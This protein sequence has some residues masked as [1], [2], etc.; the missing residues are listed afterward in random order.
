MTK[1]V[2]L[3]VDD[4]LSVLSAISRDLR[5]RYAEQYRVLRAD[6]GAAG[7]EALRELKQRNDPVALF[8]VDQRMPHMDGVEFLEQA[9]SLYPETKRVLLTAYADTDAAIQAINNAAIHY[10]LLKPW[11]PPEE[12]LY[13]ILDDL[14]DDWQANYHPP[15]SGIRIIGH[16]WS[17]EAHQLKDFLARNHVPYQYLDVEFG[18]EARQVLSQLKVEEA[19]LPVVILPDGEILASPSLA[20]LAEKVGLKT[21]AERRFYDIAIVGGGP[22][23]LAAAVYGA[24]E[25]LRTVLI[26]REATGGQAGTSSRIEN[27]LG[28]PSGLSGA[29]LARRAT[30]Q[31]KRFGVE[32]LAPQEAIGVRVDGPYRVLTLADDSEISCHAVVVAVGLTY[33]KLNVPGIDKLTGAGVY[34]GA[35]LTEA[36]LC[37]DQPVLIVGAGNSAGQA[38]LYLAQTSSKVFMLVRDDSL[39][40]K[41]SQYLVER[42]EATPTIE[43]LQRAELAA[44]HGEEHLEAVTVRYHPAGTEETLPAVGLFVFIGATPCTDWLKGVVKLD[45]RGFILTGPQLLENG[46]S[47]KAWPLEREPFLTEASIPG[48]FAVGDVRANSVK[49]VASAVGEGSITV[50]FVHQYLS[51]VR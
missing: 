43:V 17:P 10:Y 36:S 41:M 12:K 3:A 34:Y 16:R 8:L 23:G 37:E 11:D 40:K 30:T 18:A 33:R 22:A 1:P 29:E 39:G 42:I 20:T 19:K 50:Q 21:Q 44:V 48:I 26:E 24:S 31:A 15:F 2:L 27:Y 7:L 45:E 13:P 51:K 4:D 49:R 28:F 38:A 5:R 14:L 46:A 35:S 25:G 32:I 6:S 9:R 47:P